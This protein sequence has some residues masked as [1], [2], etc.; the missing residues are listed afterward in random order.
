MPSFSVL[1]RVRLQLFLEGMPVHSPVK[2]AK[3]ET[4]RRS[5]SLPKK[6]VSVDGDASYY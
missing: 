4:L 6:I 5:P 3:S 1:Q 2:K